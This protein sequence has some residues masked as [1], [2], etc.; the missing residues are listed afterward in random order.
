[1]RCRTV[2]LIQFDVVY[3]IIVFL[4]AEMT[5]PSFRVWHMGDVLKMTKTQRTLKN[6]CPTAPV[7]PTIAILG[8]SATLAALTTNEFVDKRERAAAGEDSFAG[9]LGRICNACIIFK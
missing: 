2:I 1:M 7:T 6:S 3:Q 8:P 5:K 4:D 9:A